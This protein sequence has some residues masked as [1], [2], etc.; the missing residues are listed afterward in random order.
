MFTYCIS[1]DALAHSSSWR[2]LGSGKKH[3]RHLENTCHP[4]EVRDQ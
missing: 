1:L 4:A 2:L 3:H